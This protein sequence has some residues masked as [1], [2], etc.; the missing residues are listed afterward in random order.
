MIIDFD[1]LEQSL[2]ENQ[3]AHP[4]YSIFFDSMARDI[5]SLKNTENYISP[6]DKMSF[7]ETLDFLTDQYRSDLNMMLKD[8]EVK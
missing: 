2:E 5:L 1:K 8:Y 3:P 6:I 7:D 4:N